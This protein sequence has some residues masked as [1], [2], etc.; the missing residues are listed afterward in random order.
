MH[1]RGRKSIEQQQVPGPE[2][3]PASSLAGAP[4]E[5]DVGRRI[6]ETAR[7]ELCWRYSSV[8]IEDRGAVTY[9]K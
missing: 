6:V 5:R 1:V 7:L 9:S 2:C 3:S 8:A 4:F